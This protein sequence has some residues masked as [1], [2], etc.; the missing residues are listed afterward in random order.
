MTPALAC[1]RLL[2]GRRYADRHVLG[3]AGL[4]RQ[5]GGIGGEGEVGRGAVGQE[6]ERHRQRA[7]GDVPN[8]ED[9]HG[10]P[11]GPLCAPERERRRLDRDLGRGGVHR[12]DEPAALGDHRQ[13][14]VLALQPPAAAHERALQVDG[15]EVGRA[16]A[17]RAAAPATGG[18]RARAG[19]QREALAAGVEVVRP[20]PG[21]TRSGLTRPSKATPPDEKGAMSISVAFGRRTPERSIVAPPARAACPASAG[22]ATIGTPTI[23]S[24]SREPAG[25]SVPATSTAPAPRLRAA[26]GLDRSLLRLHDDGLAGYEADPVRAEEVAEGVAACQGAGLAVGLGQRR[27]GNR[28]H[29]EARGGFRCC[30]AEEANWR[31]EH[32]AGADA[33]LGVGLQHLPAGVQRPHRERLGGGRG[34]RDR[35]E[36]EARAAVVPD[37]SDHERAEVR[38]AGRGPRL[39]AVRKRRVGLY[40]PD[41]RDRGAV[42]D[43]AVAVGIDS[44]LQPRE[45]E[46]AAATAQ[47]PSTVCR[48]PMTRIGRIREPGATPPGRTARRGRREARPS[49][50]RG[51][52][53]RRARPASPPAS[54][55]GRRRPRRSPGRCGRSGMRAAGRRPCPGA[56]W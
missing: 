9:A 40:A 43:V 26:L 55:S 49:A 48:Q 35:P 47:L 34:R 11:L 50:S 29:L 44:P 10:A 19:D 1:R 37:G 30:T 31:V 45:Q 20:T 56:Q 28:R 51:P 4:E 2:S 39:G 33:Q 52:R 16:S 17:T 42:L 32:R 15:R 12:I 24:R 46:I 41:E 14:V 54:R 8:G 5:L 23:P 38:G 6:A 18:R 36:P 22:I 53:R 21:A 25:S 3:C 7:A 13:R 27:P